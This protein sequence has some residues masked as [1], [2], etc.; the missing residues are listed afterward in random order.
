MMT[1]FNG[2][3]CVVYYVGILI[4]NREADCARRF[5]FTSPPV[6]CRATLRRADERKEKKNTENDGATMARRPSATYI[7]HKR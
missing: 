6:T 2:A 3:A 7:L 4:K 5:K 1:N